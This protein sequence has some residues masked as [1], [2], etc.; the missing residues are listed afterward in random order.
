MKQ[1]KDAADMASQQLSRPEQSGMAPPTLPTRS[2]TPS[3]SSVKIKV[4]RPGLYVTS[5]SSENFMR[6]AH[7]KPPDPEEGPSDPRRSLRQSTARRTKSPLPPPP[8]AAESDV[9]FGIY[10][11]K[12]RGPPNLFVCCL[13][14]PPFLTTEQLTGIFARC[15]SEPHPAHPLYFPYCPHPL[16]LPLNIAHTVSKTSHHEMRSS[17]P[18]HYFLTSYT[19]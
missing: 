17:S 2:S 13:S 14:S 16:R 15:T 6:F 7:R 4:S 10:Q 8:A 5:W 19:R 1:V 3:S 9:T 12:K 11:P 18:S